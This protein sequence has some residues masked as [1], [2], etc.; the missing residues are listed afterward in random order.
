MILS[1]WLHTKFFHEGLD[2]VF[3]LHNLQS[4]NFFPKFSQT[5]FVPLQNLFWYLKCKF[6]SPTTLQSYTTHIWTWI[7][8]KF[9][10]NMK[11]YVYYHLS[12]FQF[13]WFHKMKNLVIFLK[14]CQTGTQTQ[15]DLQFLLNNSKPLYILRNK[16]NICLPHLF[17]ISSLL[18][19]IRK[20]Y[21]F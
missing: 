14:P 18:M 20:T 2:N 10:C 13:I 8:L 4:P 16:L 1:T 5:V 15:N 3:M 21:Q 6:L 9:W 19:M 11:S 17:K 7:D 12:Q